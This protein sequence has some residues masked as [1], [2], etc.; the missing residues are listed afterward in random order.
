MLRNPTVFSLSK[1]PFKTKYEAAEKWVADCERTRGRIYY[2]HCPGI[3][4]SQIEAQIAQ[5][6]AKAEARGRELVVI[7]D[8]FQKI[9]WS[10]LA[11]DETKGY[12]AV[13]A[14]LK[15]IIETQEVFCI[16][17]AQFGLDTS[18]GEKKGAFGGTNINM[19]SQN[20]IR[21]EREDATDTKP[22]EVNGKAQ[23]D[24]C[25]MPMLYHEAKQPSSEATFN[26][27]LSNDDETGPVP[28][29]MINGYFQIADD[30]K[31]WPQE[32]LLDE[33]ALPTQQRM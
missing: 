12:N 5:Y 9:D 3:S 13:A 11:Q 32:W 4:C 21:V 7:I 10:E 28:V 23:K 15:D 1:E 19:V 8:Y 24:I 18:Y 20:V 33:Q 14:R 31:R 30:K 2:E 26:V 22:I 25:G 29:T 16:N 6:K 27:I 17:M